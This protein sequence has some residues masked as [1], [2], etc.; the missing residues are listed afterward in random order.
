M[1]RMSPED[2]KPLSLSLSKS[3]SNEEALSSLSG[4]A[5]VPDWIRSFEEG[6][7][8]EKIFPFSQRLLPSRIENRLK[9]APSCQNFTSIFDELNTVDDSPGIPEP[10]YK[11]YF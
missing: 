1:R 10:R 8:S 7:V 11:Q 5:E 9:E 3:M 6:G 2:M 4:I